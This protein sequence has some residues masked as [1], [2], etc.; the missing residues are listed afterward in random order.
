MNQETDRSKNESI[1]EDSAGL[2]GRIREELASSDESVSQETFELLKFH[3]TYQQDNR[4]TR[5]DRRRHGLGKEFIF[6]VR[7]RIP[8]GK[9][10]TD[11]LLGELDLAEEFGNG[12]L[13]ITTR[14]GIQL[15]GVVKGD[16]WNTI[17]RINELKLSTQSACGDVERNVVCCPAPLRHDAP[18]AVPSP[19]WSWMMSNSSAR[20]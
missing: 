1:K 18:R 4:D 11:Q 9:M 10:T 3:G 5:Q 13:R 15:H 20:W 19:V 8:G 14:Q 6:M 16:L 17:H 12:T 2:R 7:N